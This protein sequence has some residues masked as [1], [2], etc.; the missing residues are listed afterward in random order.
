MIPSPIYT[1]PNPR[2]NKDKRI[3]VAFD[4]YDK[5]PSGKY[6]IYKTTRAGCTTSL[7]AE[8]LNRKEVFLCIVPTN[9]IASETIVLEAKKYSD[10][11]NAHIVRIP[12]NHKCKINEK[13][14]EEFPDLK[15]LPILPL[16]G[17]CSK[18]KMYESCPVT[19]VLRYP[20]ADG[21]VITYKKLSALMLAS[22]TRPN[23]T[24]EKILGILSKAKNV[25]FDEVHVL[26]FEEVISYTVYN[27]RFQS[28]A[29]FDKYVYMLEDKFKYLRRVISQFSLLIS[30][31]RVQVGVREIFDN[32][33]GSDYWK[34]HLRYITKN[35][36]PGIV[37]EEN[38]TKVIIGVYN[39][40]IELT[41]NRAKYNLEMDGILDL[42][43][44]LNIVISQFISVNA[45]R[46]NSEIKVNLSAVDVAFNNMIR[47]YTMSIQGDNRR[48]FLTSATIGS[49]D[50]GKLFL[51]GEEPTKI[52]FGEMGDPIGTNSKMLILA[53]SKKYSAI[54]RN[55]IYNKMDEIVE[56]VIRI[57]TMCCD[58]NCI[59]VT[60]STKQAKEIQTAL[61]EAGH[62]HLVTYY[63][64]PYTMGVSSCA[65]VMIAIGV[66]NKPSNAFDIFTNNAE[67]SKQMLM[68]S[69]HA[70]TWQAWSRVKDP[71]GEV[72]SIVF[73]LGCSE[74]ECQAI[75]TWGF[76]RRVEIGPSINGQKKAVKVF[77]GPEVVSKPKVIKC[78]NLQAML[79]ECESHTHHKNIFA[80]GAPKPP[81]YNIIG[82]F[83]THSAKLFSKSELVG[84]FI[85]RDDVYAKQQADGSYRKASSLITEQTIKD[86]LDGTITMG[87]YQLSKEN[88][89]KWICF[90]IDSHAPRNGVETPEE[91]QKRN[92]KAETDKDELCNWLS[93]NNIPFL[94]EAS[95]SPFSYHVWI[96][97]EPVK[98]IK[99]KKFGDLVIKEL[100]ID[101]EFFP[102]QTSIN[103]HGY[104][105][106]VKAP[107]ATHR[108]HLTKSS[109]FVKGE[110]VTDFE[111]LEIGI[112][113]MSNVSLQ[114]E[115]PEDVKQTVN[116]KPDGP[117]NAPRNPVVR[118]NGTV[119][120]IRPCIEEARKRQLTGFQGHFMRIAVCRE[121]WNSGVCD[122]EKLVDLF[123]G[124]ADFNYEKS[125]KGVLSVIKREMPKVKCATL[126]E[127]SPKFVNCEGCHFS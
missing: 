49:Y 19:E 10:A 100:K 122:P 109:I 77:C 107:F 54:G 18:C 98:A 16:A 124:Q 1:R 95:G 53:D 84:M 4:I 55:S 46:D 82:G 5:Y 17:D 57:L 69:V 29:N 47:S 121:Y 119:M 72:P 34:R 32:A 75:V 13:L 37:E 106:L 74:E 90:D 126:R 93:V 91:V 64:S 76:D 103:S 113:D 22:Q 9:R 28:L 44:M 7:V 85:S 59:I 99:V 78:K 73:A 61:A 80:D 2:L 35:P 62:P 51:R 92:K 97:T 102:K 39:E 21:F 43:R 118:I 27:E 24:A 88:K 25:I 8:S 96:F 67:K 58:E 48:I 65:R 66:A 42:Y 68:E 3:E 79:V 81:I 60:R 116:V 111:E 89:V 94:L 112:V 41:K 20:D 56:H 14:C 114:E 101:C 70:D 127:N 123:R 50:Y 120:N 6:L 40:I 11:K 115:L 12:G 30:E 45:I 63:K 38:E 110:F 15:Q 108:K 125:M 23:T 36:S 71:N 117:R 87:V 86:H 33:V 83:T 52:T 26:Q 104:G 105:N 31:E